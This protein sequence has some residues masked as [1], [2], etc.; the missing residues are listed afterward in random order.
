VDRKTPSIKK[1]DYEH[2]A[3]FR[4]GLRTFLRFSEQAAQAVGLTPQ[5]HQAM[6]AIMGFPGREQVT[7]GELAE[8]LQVRHHSAV[9]LV[10]RLAAQGLVERSQDITDRRQVLVALTPRGKDILDQL[11]L[12]H[13]Q[14][15]QRIQPNLEQLLSVLSQDRDE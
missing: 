9:G 15:L 2:L 5:Q 1:S 3:A 4:Y 14:E 6:L 13:R 12:A 11:V 8:R 10:D 7:V